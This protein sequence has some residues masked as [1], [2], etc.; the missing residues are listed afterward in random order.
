M[1]RTDEII[2]TRECASQAYQDNA[3]DIQAL[4]TRLI[5]QLNDH[6]IPPVSWGHVADLG[7]VRERLA[8]VV[9]FLAGGDIETRDVL[10]ELEEGGPGPVF[11]MVG[12]LAD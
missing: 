10:M 12:Y 11:D 6:A 5:E 3:K 4:M 9:A 7:L 1:N 8:D 2:G